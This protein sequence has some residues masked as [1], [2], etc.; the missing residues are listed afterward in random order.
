MIWGTRCRL[1]AS[2]GA[3]LDNGIS[4]DMLCHRT[5]HH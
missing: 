2:D 4:L 3:V 1:S 5:A